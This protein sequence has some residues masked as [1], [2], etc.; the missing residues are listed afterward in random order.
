[1]DNELGARPEARFR[2][3]ARYTWLAAAG[4]VIALV[5]VLVTSD[6]PGRVLA[7]TATAVLAGY[8]ITDL[9]FA[10]R[11]TVSGDGLVV[12]SPFTRARLPWA[13]VEDVR[14]DSRVRL[15]LRSTT[16]EIDAGPVLVVL[17]RRALGADP[18]EVAEL[19]LAFRPR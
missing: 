2:P 18:V 10:P 9:V 15:G 12:Y 14:A 19:A 6:P 11:L 5:I 8:V 7:A 17:S 13:E 4:A 1:V 3:D 16:L